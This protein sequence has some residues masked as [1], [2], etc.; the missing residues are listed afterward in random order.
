M[1]S[2]MANS[3]GGESFDRAVQQELAELRRYLGT[4]Q[5]RQGRETGY[6]DVRSSQD[7][8]EDLTYQNQDQELRDA[9]GYLKDP[10]P[11]KQGMVGQGRVG[12]GTFADGD[13]TKNMAS[14]E[15]T[16]AARRMLVE[17]EA[18]APSVQAEMLSELRDTYPELFVTDQTRLGRNPVAQIAAKY[19]DAM[20]KNTIAGQR[21]ARRQNSTKRKQTNFY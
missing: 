15:A 9:T 6:S 16:E 12:G 10:D 2:V 8:V 5:F 3:D 1:D 19:S 14:D 18:E 17:A 13:R 11:S 20:N 4:L 21:Q 7:L